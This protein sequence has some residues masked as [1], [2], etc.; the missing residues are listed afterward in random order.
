MIDIK[1]KLERLE[2]DAAECDLISNL[3]IDM[4][5]REAFNKLAQQ[6]REMAAEIKRLIP[7]KSA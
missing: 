7:D 5:K 4:I 3:A 6:Y 1:E 2:V